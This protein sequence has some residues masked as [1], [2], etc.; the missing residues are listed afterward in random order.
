MEEQLEQREDEEEESALAAEQAAAEAKDAE[1]EAAEE[2]EAVQGRAGPVPGVTRRRRSVAKEAPAPAFSVR[3]L[4][5]RR[6]SLFHPYE[7]R[8][9]LSAG[10]RARVEVLLQ[11]RGGPVRLHMGESADGHD[12]F[13]RV[14]WTCRTR[15]RSYTFILTAHA[16][17]DRHAGAAGAF[18]LHGAFTVN[19]ARVCL[20]S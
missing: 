11:R 17:G 6:H 8:I 12:Y 19:A 20:G 15:P 14:P 16:E 18:T 1:A 5:I 3:V 9:S 7:T 4:V 2:D 13:L 10:V